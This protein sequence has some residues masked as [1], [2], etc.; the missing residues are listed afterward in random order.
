MS[1]ELYCKN[2]RQ[3]IIKDVTQEVSCEE[4]A[5]SCKTR[6]FK[7]TIVTGDGSFFLPQLFPPIVSKYSKCFFVRRKVVV[8]ST[9]GAARGGNAVR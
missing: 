1:A 3:R 4:T 6:S 7:Q 9:D 2:T 8:S 5:A